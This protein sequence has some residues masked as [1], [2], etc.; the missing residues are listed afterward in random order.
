MNYLI[1]AIVVIGLLAAAVTAPAWGR[2]V[3]A[4]ILR[5]LP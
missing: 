2:V 1:V 3:E 5:R 4:F